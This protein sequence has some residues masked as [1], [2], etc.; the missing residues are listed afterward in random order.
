MRELRTL[1]DKLPEFAP[2]S[3]VVTATPRRW[4]GAAA[5]LAS[6][7]AVAAVA[8]ALWALTGPEAG[9]QLE[10][11]RFTPFAVDPGYQMSPAWSPN[12]KTIAYVAE[13][14]GILQVFTKAVDSPLR[15]EVTHRGS[16]CLQ[17]FWGSD[18]RLY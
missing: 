14:D 7:I 13:V 9:V 10:P 2:P 1:R 3:E 17:P 5:V 12:G 11:Y 6:A 16:D 4:R 8:A 15:N 18:T